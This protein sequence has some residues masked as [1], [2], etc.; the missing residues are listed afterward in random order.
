MRTPIC[1]ALPGSGT[2]MGVIAGACEVLED[3]Y[4]FTH[5][6]GTSGGG[7][8]ALGLALGMP[9]GRLSEMVSSI[10]IR[11]D[12]LDKG[13]PF[14]QRPGLFKGQVVE[15][16]LKDVFGKKRLRDLKIP[17]RVTVVDV[18]AEAPAII[19]S[20]EHGDVLAYRAARATM[21]IPGLFDISPVHEDNPLRLAGDG[22]LALN[23]PSGI[24]DDKV[25]P[26]LALRF[27]TPVTLADLI[28]R[29]H[30]RDGH[31]KT[32]KTWTDLAFSTAGVLLGTANT[33]LQSNKVDYTEITLSSTG[34]GMK[35]GL[36]KKE[37]EQ[38]RQE[39]R[40]SALSHFQLNPSP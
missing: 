8:V 38:R 22:G 2:L 39:G 6:G 5:V 21:A 32:V 25:D 37:V 26:T 3:R 24:W 9:P 12:L 10:L 13:W 16:I 23:Q 14:D 27:T 11:K 20:V 29:G 33:T 28:A 4:R 36:T 31:K 19:D 15:Q 7:V 35:F 34:D 18:S 1:L 17:S 40:Q 30:M